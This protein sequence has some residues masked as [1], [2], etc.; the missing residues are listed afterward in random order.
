MNCLRFGHKA[1]ICKNERVCSLCSEIFHDNSCTKPTK[2]INCGDNHSSW[3]KEYTA[4]I[5]EFEIQKI[6]TNNKISYYDAKT[7]YNTLNI[8]PP[9]K[10][11]SSLLKSTNCTYTCASCHTPNIFDKKTSSVSINKIYYKKSILR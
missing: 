6:K 3:S 4:F 5:E 8:N 10:P 9:P 11:F 2:C 7:K 1:L